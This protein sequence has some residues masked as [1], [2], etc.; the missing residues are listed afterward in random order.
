MNLLKYHPL[1]L[2]AAAAVLFMP[3]DLQ[4]SEPRF[5]LVIHGGASRHS[6]EL[7]PEYHAALKEALDAGYTVLESGGSALDA[8]VAAITT[9]EDAPVFNAGRGSVLNADGFC[10]L[11]AAI[12]DG[13]DRAA[14]AVAGLKTV[15]NPI[16]LARDVMERSGHV[17]LI[18]EGAERF[19]AEMEHEPVP[20]EYFQTERRKRQLERAQ[21]AESGDVS[22]RETGRDSGLGTVGCVALD[23]EGNLAAGTSTGGRNNK[24]FG[25]VGDVPVIGAGTYAANETCAVS[26]TGEGEFFIRAV[27][28]YDIAARIAYGGTP[29]AEAATAA[30][31]EVAELGGAGGV[32]TINTK[33]EVVMRYNTPSMCRAYRLSSGEEV[34]EVF[35]ERGERVLREESQ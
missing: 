25:R 11:D 4:G 24:K 26:A 7:E 33:G 14:G 35:K 30:I 20:N 34:V 10:E 9:M 23:K 5:G 13:R 15:R 31:E 2:I 3:I 29:L 21:Q 6:K 22:L 17:M 32:I 18:G 12:M 28:S 8:V 1:P 19:A 27:A 16:L